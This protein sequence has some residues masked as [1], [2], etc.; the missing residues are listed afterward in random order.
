MTGRLLCCVAVCGWLMAS[1]P[2]QAHHALGGVYDLENEETLS[3]TL[4]RILFV[5]PHGSVTVSVKSRRHNDAMDVHDRFRPDPRRTWDRDGLRRAQGGRPDH[6]EVLSRSQWDA[7]WLFEVAH[8]RR[9][10]D[11]RAACEPLQPGPKRTGRCGESTDRQ[12]PALRRN[13][14]R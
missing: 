10:N 14:R 6:R 13:R 1:G 12:R 7:D 5:N 4:V 2:L 9:W 3:G 8:R 11:V